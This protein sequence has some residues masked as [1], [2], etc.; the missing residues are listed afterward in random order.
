MA[1]HFTPSINLQKRRY[2]TSTHQAA[3]QILF[4]LLR[5]Y[6]YP[7]FVMSMVLIN[8]RKVFK[9]EMVGPMPVKMRE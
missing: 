4:Q 6:D 9:F 8:G 1:R 3:K 7:D 5:F 2:T